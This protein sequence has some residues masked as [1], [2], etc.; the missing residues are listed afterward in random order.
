[1]PRNAARCWLMMALRSPRSVPGPR[2]NVSRAGD[3]AAPE[4]RVARRAGVRR[5][6]EE[7]EVAVGVREAERIVVDLGLQPRIVVA[8]LATAAAVGPDVG[9]LG[10]DVLLAAVE[11]DAVDVPGREEGRDLVPPPCARAGAGRVEDEAR[12]TDV[13]AVRRARRPGDQV[14]E[15]LRLEAVVA[16]RRAADPGAAPGHDPEAPLAERRQHLGG[17]RE[18]G[19]VPGPAR[20]AE[21]ALEH[22]T[23]EDV[24][25]A[26]QPERVVHQQVVGE[27]GV[28]RRTVH[29][30]RRPHAQ[31]APPAP[32]E[33]RPVRRHDGAAVQRRV[34]VEDGRVLG[35][36]EQMQHQAAALG[37]GAGL[38]AELQ[39]RRDPSSRGRR[40]RTSCRRPR[41]RSRATTGRTA[42][43]WRRSEGPSSRR[44]RRADR[45]IPPP[46]GLMSSAGTSITGG[47]SGGESRRRSV[48]P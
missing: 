10:R 18:P 39:R 26:G 19:L 28:D 48:S 20:E 42:R 13:G 21:V 36:D 41:D 24:H 14:A 17:M 15:P 34:L 12:A 31:L 7:H 45:A 9:G 47:A 29:L 32:V 6:R 35:A 2:P 3:V 23:I 27:V 46:A 16:G 25:A 43:R 11:L 37:R 40:R 5:P 22:G 1:M 30:D 44:P 33:E 8:D 4:D 38:E